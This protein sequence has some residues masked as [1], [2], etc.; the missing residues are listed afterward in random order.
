MRK[1]FFLCG[2]NVSISAPSFPAD[3]DYF[4]L[5]ETEAST[6]D[7]SVSCIAC[8][9]LPAYEGVFCGKNESAAVYCKENDIFRYTP[10]GT[11]SG[12]VTRYSRSDFSCST[13]FI[14]ERNYNVMMD[15]RY[16][17][18]TI[19]LSQLMLNKNVLFF[20]ASFIDFGGNGILFSAP[21]GT[22]KST[23]ASLWEKHRN[24]CIING[25]KAGVSIKDGVVYANGVPF[26]GTSDICRNVT[27]P[28]K[29]IVLLEQA[30]ENQAELL[31]GTCALQ[32]LMKNIYLDMIAPDEQRKCVDLLIDIM[33]EVPVYLLK[34]TPDEHAV[35]TLEKVL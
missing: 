3:S 2:Q 30:K 21:C 31:K 5:F 15:S 17:W 19:A 8:A 11:D 26:C 10:M 23:Q 34:C 25:D 33:A 32:M 16:M 22:G 9:E 14:A 7:L 6:P 24:A 18:S 13:T 12:A 27:V 20:H 35:E 4:G 28:L 29:A 1:N